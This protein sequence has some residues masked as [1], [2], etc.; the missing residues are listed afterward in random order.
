VT[1]A[2]SSCPGDTLEVLLD[3]G[4]AMARRIKGGAML[5]FLAVSC[6]SSGGG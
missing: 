4:E 5:G 1:P 3:G 2:A 6:W